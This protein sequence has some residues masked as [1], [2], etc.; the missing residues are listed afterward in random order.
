V[1]LKAERVSGSVLQHALRRFPEVV[2]HVPARGVG[3]FVVAV[4]L[5]ELAPE[6]LAVA[7]ELGYG[8]GVIS[9]RLERG[10]IVGD[11]LA[12]RRPARP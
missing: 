10:F 5:A 11:S 9:I 3:L 12:R 2:D 4:G 7:A 8:L 6:R 1:A